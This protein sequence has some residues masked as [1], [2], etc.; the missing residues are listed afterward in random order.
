MNRQDVRNFLVPSAIG[1][2][3]AAF[4]LEYV[5]RERPLGDAIWR[6]MWFFV[7]YTAGH[8]FFEGISRIHEMWKDAAERVGKPSSDFDLDAAIKKS[9]LV[10][11]V[12]LLALYARDK[13]VAFAL[14]ALLAGPVLWKDWK[15]SR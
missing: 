12:I 10:S 15:K 4:A 5:Y 9:A 1:T 3:V 6:G 2:V 7:F 14:L 13:L 11:M 8:F